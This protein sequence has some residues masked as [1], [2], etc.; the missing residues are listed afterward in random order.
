MDNPFWVNG[1]PISDD[2]D[3][4]NALLVRQSRGQIPGEAIFLLKNKPKI[5]SLTLDFAPR[6]SGAENLEETECQHLFGIS[7]SLPISIYRFALQD[8]E[9]R[10]VNLR[11]SPTSIIPALRFDK[12]KTLTIS[13]CNRPDY[14]LF[15]LIRDAYQSPPR[16]ESLKICHTRFENDFIVETIEDF[17]LSSQNCLKNLWI[18]IR[19]SDKLPKVAAISAHASTLRTLFLDVRSI[20]CIIS[21]SI[22]NGYAVYHNFEDWELLCGNLHDLE[23]LAAAFPG[24]TVNPF[25]NVY[26]PPQFSQYLVSNDLMNR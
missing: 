18:T 1:K 15:A 12:L 4:L 26:I 5:N 14:F 20:A 23:Q 3:N 9:L 22:N 10:G 16:L 21:H 19:A 17:L 2:M 11:C 13:A 25:Y 7:R 8:L 24:V 6:V